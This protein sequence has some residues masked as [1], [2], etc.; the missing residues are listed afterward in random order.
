[1]M[2]CPVCTCSETKPFVER[3]RVTTQQNLLVA[4]A[5]Q[6]R[7]MNGGSL[8][9]H[10]C[11]QCGF[12]FN[13]AFDPTLLTYDGDYD[14]TQT[15]S[16]YFQQYVDDLV[17]MLINERGVRDSTI[18]EV[19]CGKGGFLRKLVEHPSAQN[20]GVG[21]DPTY[22][23]PNTDFDGRLRFERRFYDQHAANIKPDVVICRHV[24]E[25]VPD[26]VALLRSVR[27]AIGDAPHAKVFFETPDVRWILKHGVVWDFFYEHCSLFTS[28]S[29]AAAFET[30][31]FEVNAVKR[32]FGEQ[33]LWIEAQPRDVASPTYDA[34]D[35]ATLADAF[36]HA[37]AQRIARWRDDL[38][39]YA[40]KGAVAL[41]GAGA[42]GVTLA[43]LIDPDA[44]LINCVVDVNPGKQGRFLPG[45]AH[46]I[47][48]PDQLSA[49]GVRTAVIL[50]PNYL[51][52]IR[53]TI[54]H[55]APQVT[56]VNLMA[57]D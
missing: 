2:R 5:D 48:A 54:G 42:K 57:D 9:M 27:R 36:A 38:T 44:A 53:A 41:W 52:E 46:P 6:A 26:P 45:T 37:E 10:A 12:T 35:V 51:N 28:G 29:L 30:A 21:F 17:A 15:H 20:R 4:D 39:M 43:N 13:A 50:N 16:G 40:S 49:R 25:H 1:M 33:Y 14:N 11:S 31:G 8:I 19:G 18:V 47:V 56:A 22:V 55:T 32:I 34:G 3:H 23:G 24:I 7:A